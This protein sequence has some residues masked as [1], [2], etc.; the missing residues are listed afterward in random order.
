MKKMY[1]HGLWFPI[2]DVAPVSQKQ[3]IT[4]HTG[5]PQTNYEVWQKE[6]YGNFIKARGTEFLERY[7]DKKETR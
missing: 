5:E 1:K 7:I 3:V 2:T 6:K 4:H